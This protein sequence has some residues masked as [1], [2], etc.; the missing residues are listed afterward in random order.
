MS[1]SVRAFIM[2][3][4]LVAAPA[5]WIY[6]GPLP[7][8]AQEALATLAAE[9]KRMIGWDVQG[10]AA[11]ATSWRPAPQSHASAASRADV[12]QAAAQLGSAPTVDV[13]EQRPP[14]ADQVEPLLAELR[15]RGVSEYALEHWGSSGEHFRFYCLMPLAGNRNQTRQFEAIAN[16]PQAA[17]REVLA[18][19]SAWQLARS[20]MTMRR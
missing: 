11:V 16:D 10:E 18:E 14:M 13:S 17:I 5:A 1:A 2:L 20:E 12:P 19:A 8:E 6:Y 3:A 15:H 9:G 4:V 7:A